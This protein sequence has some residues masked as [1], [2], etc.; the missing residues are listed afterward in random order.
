MFIRL[1]DTNFSISSRNWPL[2]KRESLFY[3]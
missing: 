2:F 3:Q 1:G